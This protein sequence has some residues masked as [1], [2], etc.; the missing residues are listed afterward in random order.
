M[1]LDTIMEKLSEIDKKVEV[2]MNR[3]RPA[4]ACRKYV[5]HKAHEAIR[6]TEDNKN[7]YQAI[8]QIHNK[9]FDRKVRNNV[10]WKIVGALFSISLGSYGF[11]WLVYRMMLK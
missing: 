6:R 8:A 10:F 11:T 3:E 5:E 2:L 4:E 7:E 9:R 1:E